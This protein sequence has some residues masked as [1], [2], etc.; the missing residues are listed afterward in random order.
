MIF[1]NMKMEFMKILSGYGFYLCVLF[2]GLLCFSAYIYEDV[3]DGN[4]Y[5]VLRSF[6]SF[7]RKFMLEDTTFCSFEVI[8][9]S[10]GNW[11][12][13]FV[14]IIAAFAFVPLVCDEHESGAVRFE[15]VRS[16][17]FYLQI[18]FG[19]SLWW[20]CRNDRIYYFCSNR[21]PFVSVY[22]FL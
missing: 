14:P 15:V 17:K 6:L 20:S 22:W 13:L 18:F 21:P 7:D 10:A 4:K 2:T 8:R 12:F 9:N 16:N 19:L 5:S 3:M 1:R 11:L